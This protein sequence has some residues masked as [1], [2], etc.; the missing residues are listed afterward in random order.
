MQAKPSQVPV[1]ERQLFLDFADVS[2]R[3][4]L[5]HTLHPPDK[6]GA[7]IEPE[8][9]DMVQTRCAP[10]WVPEDRCY[11]I[12]V[13]EDGGVSYA[14]SEDGLH[15][16][17]PIL[18]C[19]EHRG[20]LENS[21]VSPL[22]GHQ[23][24]YDPYDPDPSR[25]Y[26]SMRLRGASERMVS[27]TA[28]HWKL[29][30]N[31]WRLA[32]PARHVL[33]D[34]SIYQLSWVINVEEHPDA[35][36][37]ERF[38]GWGNFQTQ[39]LM[40]SA[41]GIHWRKLECPGLPSGD[42]ANL[43]YDAVTGTYIATLKEGEMGPH[44]R[45]IALATSQDFEHWSGPE[46][47][48]HADAQDQE[49]ARQVIAAR[50]ANA[51]LVQPQYNVPAEYMVDV[52]NMGICRYEGLYIG[53]AAFFYHTGNVDENSDGFHHVQLLCSRDLHNWVRLGDRQ[54][55]IG[56]SEV[57][58]DAYDLTQIMPPS[59][60]V[61]IDGA[62]WFY[63]MGGRYRNVPAHAQQ[64]KGA[65]NLATLRRDGFMSLDAGA[66]GGSLTTT[67]F[68]LNSPWL[69][70]NVDAK[71]GSFVVEVMDGEGAVVARSR[72]IRGDQLRYPVQWESGDL[73]TQMFRP[74]RLCFRLHNAAFY[75]YWFEVGAGHGVV[76]EGRRPT[77]G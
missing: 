75:S 46:L 7:V 19:R 11:K 8:I 12:W 45:S 4:D 42:E 76:I 26:K 50:L 70:V 44:G 41:D 29:L 32:Y 74:I 72:E 65:I 9:S 59:R 54:A 20:S 66:T 31:P 25:R 60:P 62:L 55:F 6:K 53:M 33:N 16:N 39:D 49:R 63:Y 30:D 38:S 14:E 35:D 61:L 21:F 77:T 47:I 24:I 43:N 57:D 18:R 73:Q 27:P 3:E 71:Q 10:V 13:F 17:R 56:P 69:Y 28:A 2:S 40:V 36:P 68:I 48:F 64:K 52:Y 5:Q 34:P 22:C 67:N 1:G 51:K 15:W 37:G 23:V 58:S